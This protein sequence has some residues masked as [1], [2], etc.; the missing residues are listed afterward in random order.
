MILFKIKRQDNENST[1]YW[2]YFEVH[3]KDGMTV[4]SALRLIRHRPV[5]LDGRAVSPVVWEDHCVA[6]SCGSCTI[7]INGRVGSA[8]TTF[9]H[10]LDQPIR[11]EPLTKFK[12]MRDLVVDK[13]KM[14]QD[15]TRIQ[16]WMNLDG[17]YPIHKRNQNYSV[18]ELAQNLA[19]CTHCGACLEACPQYHSDSKFVGALALSQIYRYHS[20]PNGQIEKSARLHELMQAGGISDCD[21]A[22]NCVRVC[23]VEIPLN[24]A[25]GK[26]KRQ[27]TGEI[28]KKLLG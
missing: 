2:D 21:N 10:E 24:T 25:I 27:V 26:V 22:Q 17:F 11:L 20:H 18:N 5:N 7:L 6:E 3:P 19:Q 8:C 9:I 23:P 15:L 13:S 14:Y 28:F 4:I 12:V 16:A 1:S